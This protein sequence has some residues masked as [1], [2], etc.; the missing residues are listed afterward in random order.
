M[1]IE[2]LPGTKINEIRLN[3]V[4]NTGADTVVTTCPYCLQMMEEAIEHKEI[5]NSLKARDLIELVANVM[6]QSE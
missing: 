3:D 2:E 5:K 1:W 6:E 4:L